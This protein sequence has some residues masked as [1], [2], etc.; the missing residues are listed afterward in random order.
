[1]HAWLGVLLVVAPLAELAAP[2][3]EEGGPCEHDQKRGRPGPR[4]NA[5]LRVVGTAASCELLS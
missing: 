2:K 1:M 3:E 5:E 4:S